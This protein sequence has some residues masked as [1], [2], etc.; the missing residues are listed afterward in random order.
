MFDNTG[1]IKLPL[2]NSSDIQDRISNILS[3]QKNIWNTGKIPSY[4]HIVK[5][6]LGK[7]TFIGLLMISWK[8]ISTGLGPL[9]P[10][11]L[12]CMI[13]ATRVASATS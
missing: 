6:S 10:N 3:Y 1:W 12:P 11:I 4:Q 5:H 13:S 2:H 8:C 9:T 7:L